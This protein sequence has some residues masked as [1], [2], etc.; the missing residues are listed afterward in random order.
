MATKKE[1]TVK[2]P[3]IV[4]EPSAEEYVTVRIPLDRNEGG[5]KVVWVND[6]RFIIKRGVAV[7]V[8][9]CVAEQLEHEER[10]FNAR[11]EYEQN[12]AKV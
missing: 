5:D 6:R 1:T 2:E 10:M 3:E 11:I 4:E 9:L 7:D 8:P 12:R